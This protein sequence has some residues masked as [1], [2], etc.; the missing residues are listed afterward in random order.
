MKSKKTRILI[1]VLFLVGAI[2]A[3]TS[4]DSLETSITSTVEETEIEPIKTEVIH[5]ATPKFTPTPSP[6][7]FATITAQMCNLRSGPGVEFSAIEEGENGEVLPVY[8]K[9]ADGSWLWVDWTR[10]LWISFSVVEL[11]V[12]ISEVPLV[13]DG[14][15][16]SS[17]IAVETVEVESVTPT[18]KFTATPNSAGLSE[19]MNDDGRILGVSDIYWSNYIGYYRPETGNIFVSLYIIAKNNTDS[20]E[21]FFASDI[22]LVDG[23]GEVHGRMIIPEKEPS[24]SSCTLIPGGTC[25]GWWTA[26]ILDKPEVKENLSIRWDP[27]WF[28]CDTIELPINQDN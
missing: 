22:N 23:N 3:C 4:S 2:L 8:G 18:P 9:N 6:Q 17:K 11:D 15:I 10:S 5:T 7:A 24:F 1:P 19:W 13:D 27:C 16:L 14:L 12:D 28:F 26:E 25:E 21:S 20:D